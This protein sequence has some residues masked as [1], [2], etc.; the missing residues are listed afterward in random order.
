MRDLSSR[1]LGSGVR[2]SRR[3]CAVVSKASPGITRCTLLDGNQVLKLR[4]LVAAVATLCVL[5]AWDADAATTAYEYDALGRLKVVRHQN[6]IKA[7]YSYDAAG[8]RLLSQAFVTATTPLTIPAATIVTRASTGATLTVE[9]GGLS[10]SGFVTFYDGGTYV[11]TAPVIDG[12]ATISVMG[13]SLGSHS[14]TAEFSGDAS[15]PSTSTSFVVRI[16]NLDWLPSVLD[17]LLD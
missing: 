4:S 8:N 14:I 12:V 15:N 2:S 11:G 3:P 6:Q 13:L 1:D 9:V 17:L 5:V 7:Q 10:P 16:V